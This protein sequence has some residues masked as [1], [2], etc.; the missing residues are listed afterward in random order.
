VI[1]LFLELFQSSVTDSAVLLLEGLYLVEKGIGLLVDLVSFILD[2][3]NIVIVFVAQFLVL[4]GFFNEFPCLV[5]E[6]VPFPC[7]FAGQCVELVPSVL[8]LFR[9]G[10][11]LL[12]FSMSS[13]NMGH[14][15]RQFSRNAKI[16]CS[17]DGPKE[18]CTFT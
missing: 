4:L 12:S 17:G 11:N 15:P 6:S 2:G 3:L 9:L 7:P 18:G 8:V 13:F 14:H 16:P 10:K 1:D 5:V